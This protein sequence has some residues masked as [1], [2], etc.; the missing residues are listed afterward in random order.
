MVN[1]E[2]SAK[3]FARAGVL[4]TMTT[5]TTMTT[6]KPFIEV[7]DPSGEMLRKDY[8]PARR[9]DLILNPFDA[10]PP[11]SSVTAKAITAVDCHVAAQRVFLP[12]T[13]S[14][15][16]TAMFFNKTSQQLLQLL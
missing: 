1:A 8:N 7:Y 10:R 6:K 15:D 11:S 13:S 4:S 3:A 2:E 14:T 5:T 16:S 12:P 9:G